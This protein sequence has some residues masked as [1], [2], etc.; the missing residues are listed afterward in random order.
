MNPERFKVLLRGKTPVRKDDVESMAIKRG[1]ILDFSPMRGKA[2]G[3]IL[4]GSRFNSR[5]VQADRSP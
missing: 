4:P 1:K 3:D 5:H 2:A